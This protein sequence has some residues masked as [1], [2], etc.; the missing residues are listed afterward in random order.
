MVPTRPAVR[1]LSLRRAVAA[2]LLAGLS[3]AGAVTVV[4]APTS[5]PAGADTTASSVT[6]DTTGAGLSP[7]TETTAPTVTTDPT[8][9]TT[10]TEPSTTTTTWGVGGSPTAVP[11]AAP[12]GPAAPDQGVLFGSHVKTGGSAAAQKSGVQALEAELGRTLAIDHYYHP[13]TDPF[14]TTRE[15][16]DFD[17]GR[18]PMIS[19]AKTPVDQIVDGSQD[20]FIRSR[21]DAI[22]ALGQPLFIRW[23]WEMEGK[24]NLGISESPALY[25][26]AF[27]RIVTIFRQEGATNVGWV[28][29]P[30]ASNFGNGTAQQYYPGD[31]YV[32]WVCA[33]GYDWYMKPGD[34]DSSFKTVF[35]SFYAWAI[36][37]GKPI[38]V[39]EY[40]VMDGGPTDRKASWVDAAR[41]TLK[42]ADT[43]IDA[44]VYFNSYGNDDD[45]VYHDWRMDT[46]ASSLNAF[47]LMG[48]DPYFNGG[49][50]VPT[51][52]TTITATSGPTGTVRA[53]AATFTFSSPSNPAA[54]FACRLDGPAFSFTPCTS[55]FNTTGLAD[56]SH[57]FEV[58]ATTAGGTDP[59]AAGRTWTVDTTGP[60]V[61]GLTPA[62][63]TGGVS[64]DTTVSATFSEA[65]DP[66]T[67][68]PAT[69]TLTAPGA[70]AVPAAVA[71]AAAART[72]TLTPSA[73][74]AFNTTYTVTIKGGAAGVADVVG[75]RM[76]AD[77]VWRFTTIPPPPVPNTFLNSGPA[78]LSNSPSATVTFSS[79]Q[80]DAA[81]QC[82]LDGG[83]FTDCASPDTLT[84]LADGSHTFSVR[85]W[86]ID[87]GTD[88]DPAVRTWRVDTTAPTVTSTVP[89]AGASGVA[90]NS[91]VTAT[92]SEDVDAATVTASSF[93]VRNSDGTAVRA[94]IT[95][96]AAGRSATLTPTAPLAPASAYTVA[97]AG[98]TA[99]VA[100]VAG[101]RLATD[102][103]WGFS[104]LAPVPD[105]TIDPASGPSGT[106]TATSASFA[107]SSD[108]PGAA[109][110]CSLD[111]AAATACASPWTTGA[112]LA[113]GPHTFQVTAWTMYG[114]ADP[115]PAQRTWT[116]D[117]T[118]PAVT[119]V[120]PVDG[121]TTAATTAA[122]GAT[123]S[124]PVAPATL[125]SST[126]TLT[127]AGGAAV[128]A[129]VA[130]DAGTGSAVLTPA[131]PLPAGAGFT[132][133]V[134]GGPAGVADVAGNRMAADRVWHFTTAATATSTTFTPVADARVEKAHASTNYGSSTSLAVDTGK[135]A[136]LR[137]TVSGLAGT[138]HAA[139]LRLYVTNGTGNGPAVFRTGN[140][141]T[142]KGTGSITWKNRPAPTGAVLDDKGKVAASAWVEFDVTPAVTGNGT[143]SFVL[144]GQSSDSFAAYSRENPGKAP[145]LVIT[146]G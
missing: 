15:Q 72:V 37:T 107:F 47:A 63:G 87:G 17:N 108:Q 35:K 133:T 52:D 90:V 57:T 5:A 123:F 55:P 106:V 81:F 25:I 104:T 31:D 53:T 42:T 118:P 64:R 100:D 130:W 71:Y 65:V 142:E 121:S 78:D 113:D 30:D 140:T 79:D 131:A 89:V 119:A 49:P 50:P 120:T 128:A 6:T 109:F 145:Q 102:R 20:A 60:T 14:P 8:D 66:T 125:S 143:V 45:G 22:A 84:G 115:N 88:P 28:W 13:W 62:D 122:V 146:T 1:R 141:W 7:V 126:F 16:W 48:A 34:S 3:V 98:G 24:R 138:V 68:A 136:Y 39:G 67:V 135:A 2:A 38:M 103:T 56:G 91:A 127:G 51:P 54:T 9:T 19:W 26:A 32:D 12:S 86:T 29:C 18:I 36:T 59:T 4:L 58:R 83:A 137:F 82:Q 111:G 43:A 132:V 93:T 105:T 69:V 96:N 112:P 92:F 99:G 61:G 77:K 114:G 70:V 33:D 134:K 80:P 75:N 21:A 46:S 117:T 40:G 44:V 94:A 85:A 95:Y 23:F 139:K 144:T 129:T 97:V 74:L 116:V 101:N 124:E 10:T 76:A 110:L 41:D 27:Q 73:R 11:G